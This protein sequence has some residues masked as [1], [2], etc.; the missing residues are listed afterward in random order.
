M[1]LWHCKHVT[2]GFVLEHTSHLRPVSSFFLVPATASRPSCIWFSRKSSVR[3]ASPSC[4][5]VLPLHRGHIT[6]RA[7]FPRICS[8][9]SRQNVWPQWS[10]L[11]RVNLSRQIGQFNKASMAG[12]ESSIFG[13]RLKYWRRSNTDGPLSRPRLLRHHLQMRICS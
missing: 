3:L 8:R 7:S 9:H 2:S 13:N 12:L 1:A 6:D 11:G 4:A 5:N 10:S